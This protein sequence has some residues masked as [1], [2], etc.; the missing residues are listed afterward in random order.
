MIDDHLP[1]RM[2]EKSTIIEF[3]SSVGRTTDAGLGQ[4]LVDDAPVLHVAA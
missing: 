3:D 2:C 4:V 1:V